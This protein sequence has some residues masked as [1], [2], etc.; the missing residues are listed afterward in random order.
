M[1]PEL[2]FGFVVRRWIT[3]ARASRTTGDPAHASYKLYERFGPSSIP[4]VKKGWGAKGDLD[5]GLIG[6]LAKIED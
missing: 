3:V 5:L 4:E 2:G 6:R 1:S